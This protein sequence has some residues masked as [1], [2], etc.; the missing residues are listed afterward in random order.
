[1]ENDHLAG[2]EL[3]F[4]TRSAWLQK[5][6]AHM[7][8]ITVLYVRFLNMIMDSAVA[9]CDCNVVEDISVLNI[10]MIIFI[11]LVGVNKVALDDVLVD[12]VF[13]FHL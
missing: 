9:S 13:F 11:L 6:D 2:N 1:M 3:V 12:R 7:W 4:T 8:P 10:R 5:V